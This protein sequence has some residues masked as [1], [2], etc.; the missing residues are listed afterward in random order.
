MY[1]TIQRDNCAFFVKKKSM[2]QDKNYLLWRCNSFA[3]LNYWSRSQSW[4]EMDKEAG[5]WSI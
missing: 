3:I 4:E 2:E 1:Y 5:N